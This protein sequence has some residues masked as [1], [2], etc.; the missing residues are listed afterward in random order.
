MTTSLK[1]YSNTWRTLVSDICWAQWN[2]LGLLGTGASNAYSTD[3]ESALLLAAHLFQS[4][5]RLLSG[6][7]DWLRRYEGI[8]NSE[9]LSTLLRR[10]KSDFLARV[11]GGLMET[12][13][14][15]PPRSKL[16][17]HDQILQDN[18]NMRYRYLFGPSIRAD[19]MYLLTVSH[20]CERKHDVDF[21]T[22]VRIAKCHLGCNYS[23]IK[24]IQWS[25][26]EGNVL[27]P[28]RELRNQGIVTWKVSDP[29][30]L[31]NTKKRDKG[32]IRW[33]EVNDL[34]F[35]TLQLA[36]T[37]ETMTDD[38]LTRFTINKFHE[39]WFPTLDDHTIPVPT[40]YGNGLLPLQ[41]HTTA[42]LADMTTRAL[43]SLLEHISH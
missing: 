3:I 1:K 24:R 12:T 25:L 9:R 17:D 22:A 38:T 19:V 40:P 28:Q 26:E 2:R 6:I 11:I 23:T 35:A 37:L 39:T 43:T 18:V 13:A 36:T 20:A 14:K 7:Q 4:D 31:L 32:L 27:T 16:K 30:V 33:I 8:V 42:E 15:N 34:L 21:L 41:D 29:S 5:N 10:S